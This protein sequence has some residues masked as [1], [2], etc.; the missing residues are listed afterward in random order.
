MG[1][2]SCQRA[3]TMFIVTF[4]TEIRL[5]G[6]FFF[7]FLDAAFCAA[8]IWQQLKQERKCLCSAGLLAAQYTLSARVSA[9]RGKRGNQ[10]TPIFLTHCDSRYSFTF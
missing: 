10:N 2:A 3:S 7:F 1:V 6:F 4:G 5:R 8:E 9:A